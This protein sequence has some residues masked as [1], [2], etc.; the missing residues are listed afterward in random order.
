MRLLSDD[1]SGA[2]PAAAP[3]RTAFDA[4]PPD[5]TLPPQVHTAAAASACTRDPTLLLTHLAVQ[6]CAQKNE[7]NTSYTLE[8]SADGTAVVLTV[9]VGRFLDTADVLVD[10][11]PRLVRCIIRGRLLQVHTPEVRVYTLRVLLLLHAS[12]LIVTC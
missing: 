5:G 2:P 1:C 10:V 8:E 12:L 6:C 7:G 4:L 11:Q 9:A 3:L